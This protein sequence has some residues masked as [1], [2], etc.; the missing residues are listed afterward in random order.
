MA[1]WPTLA[2][3]CLRVIYLPIC[4]N[5]LQIFQPLRQFLPKMGLLKILKLALLKIHGSNAIKNLY[6]KLL[7]KKLQ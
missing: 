2:D 6:K 7:I 5:T 1:M 3:T 4:G